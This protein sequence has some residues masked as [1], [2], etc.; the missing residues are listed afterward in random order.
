MLAGVYGGRYGNPGD[1][2]SYR[3]QNGILIT[4]KGGLP[5]VAIRKNGNSVTITSGAT[6]PDGNIRGR[7]EE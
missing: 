3:N 4:V 1:D 6:D 2:D 7:I 5:G